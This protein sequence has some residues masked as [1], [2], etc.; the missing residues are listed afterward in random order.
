MQYHPEPGTEGCLV[1]DKISFK[2]YLTIWTNKSNQQIQ[3]ITPKPIRA[4]D[5]MDILTAAA[6]AQPND[7]QMWQNQKEFAGEVGLWSGQ[8]QPHTST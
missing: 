2:K 1:T 4:L 8:Q 3:K 6:S 7:K 5:R